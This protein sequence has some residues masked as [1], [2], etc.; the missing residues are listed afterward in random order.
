[1]VQ[2]D[3]QILP[4]AKFHD[5]WHTII[6][7]GRSVKDLPTPVKCH[8]DQGL[9]TARDLFGRDRPQHW[10]LDQMCTDH[11]RLV[12]ILDHGDR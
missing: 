9:D 7:A 1:M 6:P 12:D 8:Q 5:P 11:I 10:A 3:G 2:V 4:P